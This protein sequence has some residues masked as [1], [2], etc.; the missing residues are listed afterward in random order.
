MT[1]RNDETR[2]LESIESLSRHIGY[3][4]IEARLKREL[5]Q[6][7]TDLK[8]D[9]SEQVTAR[10]RGEIAMLEMCIAMPETLIKEKSK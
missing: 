6:K 4:Q 10:L 7:L 9:Q 8:R 5:A 2:K 1:P 3:L